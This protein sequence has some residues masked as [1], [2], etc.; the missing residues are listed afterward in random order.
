MFEKHLIA[1][2]ADLTL[3]EKLKRHVNL[4]AHF[5]WHAAGSPPS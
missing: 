3:S 2:K 4:S 5:A 1:S